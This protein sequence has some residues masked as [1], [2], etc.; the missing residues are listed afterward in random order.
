LGYTEEAIRGEYSNR[1]NGV[2]MAVFGMLR[3][4]GD[5]L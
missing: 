4:F 1:P 5:D 2:I 3:E